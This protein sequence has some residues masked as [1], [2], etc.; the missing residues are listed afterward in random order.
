VFSEAG[1]CLNG[2]S[3]A[4]DSYILDKMNGYSRSI[5]GRWWGDG[6]WRW[7]Y[8]RDLWAWMGPKSSTKIDRVSIKV[9][10]FMIMIIFLLFFIIQRDLSTNM[11][12]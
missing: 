6:F 3:L 11:I 2:S 12:T 8:W 7:V 1:R 4:A 9:D 10:S 5:S